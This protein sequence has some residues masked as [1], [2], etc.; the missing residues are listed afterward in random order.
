MT[1]TTRNGLI[2]LHSTHF[3]W[4]IKSENG[5]MTKNKVYRIEE[6]IEN[7]HQP[8]FSFKDDNGILENGILMQG[9]W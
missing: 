3:R 9:D 8:F 4:I 1:A 7:G 2:P 5:V 6:W